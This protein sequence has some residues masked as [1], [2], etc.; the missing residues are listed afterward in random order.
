M[1]I[2]SVA[3]LAACQGASFGIGMEGGVNPVTDGDGKTVWFECGMFC[4]VDKDGKVGVGSS[5]RFQLSDK[6]ID[7]L[8]GNAGGPALEI[9]A[10]CG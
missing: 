1:L 10:Q 2:F 9:H 7:R 3:A 4:V 6:I 8:K 5:A